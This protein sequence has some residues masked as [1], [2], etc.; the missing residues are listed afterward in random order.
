[1]AAQRGCVCDPRRTVKSL[2]CQSSLEM[3]EGEGS[4]V[5]FLDEV[6]SR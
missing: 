1:M 5:F 4:G 6:V 2:G 3:D